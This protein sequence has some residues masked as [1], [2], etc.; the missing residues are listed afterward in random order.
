MLLYLPH[1][2]RKGEW[3]EISIYCLASKLSVDCKLS[4]ST[5][6]G[7]QRRGG[8]VTRNTC[9]RRDALISACKWG[10]R[11]QIIELV[12][13]DNAIRQVVSQ[14][15]L[16]SLIIMLV[17]LHGEN[18]LLHSLLLRQPHIRTA[19]EIPGNPHPGHLQ[20]TASCV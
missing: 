10:S 6:S 2:A 12:V 5:E 11:S 7:S 20:T 19:P 18:G 4:H 17:D 8:R 15:C 1:R 3:A 14:V 13:S 16:N 9:D